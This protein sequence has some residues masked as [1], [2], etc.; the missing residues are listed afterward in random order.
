VS[1]LPRPF[2]SARDKGGRRFQP[3]KE[4]ALEETA[5]RASAALPGA[6]DGLLVLREVVGPLGIPDLVA[7]VGSPLA[8]YQ[9]RKLGVPPLLNEIDAAMVGAASPRA[10]RRIETLARR[11]GWPVTTLARR[12]PDLLRSG[13]LIETNSGVVVRPEA[14]QP[15]GRLYAVE[16]K[17]SDWRRAVRQGRAYQLWCD[18]YIVVMESL[19]SGPLSALVA[20]TA[21]DGAGV[22]IGGRWLSRPKVRSRQ[23]WRRLWGSEHVV[24]ALGHGLEPLGSAVR[25]ESGK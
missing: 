4:Q 9:R 22:V 3:V 15:I 13:A 25:L 12:M 5:L 7:V 11:L 6:G 14:L 17:V 1:D 24:A 2:Q 21:E 8:V 10:P 18:A 20:A 19:S 16:T 23:E